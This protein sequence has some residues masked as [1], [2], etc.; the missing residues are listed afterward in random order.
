MRSRAEQVRGTLTVRG[1]HE[2]GTTVEL[3]VPA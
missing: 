2:T 3:E 1:E